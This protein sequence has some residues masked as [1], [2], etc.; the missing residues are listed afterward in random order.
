MTDTGGGAQRPAHPTLA[1]QALSLA[2]IALTLALAYGSWYAYSVVLVALLNDFGW[3]RSVLGG[4][5]SLFALVQGAANPLLGMV[6]D[7]VR[8]PAVVAAHATSRTAPYLS[9]V[10]TSRADAKQ[11]RVS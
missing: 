1:R 9:R 7:K 2:L 10:T 6:C 11:R 4:A 8:P 5:F 3:S